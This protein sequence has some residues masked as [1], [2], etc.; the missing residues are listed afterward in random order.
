MGATYHKEQLVPYYCNNISVHA[1]NTVEPAPS[2]GSGERKTASLLFK[3]DV[4]FHF[5]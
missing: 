1:V 3:L 4:K 2:L 5:C